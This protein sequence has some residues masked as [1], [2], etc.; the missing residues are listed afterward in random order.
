MIWIVCKQLVLTSSLNACVALDQACG[1]LF[2]LQ[3]LTSFE[4]GQTIV[5]RDHNMVDL[6]NSITNSKYYCHEVGV[7]V[8][9]CQTC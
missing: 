7:T 4:A 9:D 6:A 5:E 8:D 1:L 2:G 3:W